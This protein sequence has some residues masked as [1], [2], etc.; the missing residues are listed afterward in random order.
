MDPKDISA[1]TGLAEVYEKKQMLKQAAETWQ[2]YQDKEDQKP[3]VT[4]FIEIYEKRGFAAARQ[5]YLEVRFSFGRR[6]IEARRA[7]G[8]A[9]PRLPECHARSKKA[10]IEVSRTGLRR[11]PDSA[12]KSESR[13]PI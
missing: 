1:L 7:M 5:E 13:F 4:S 2:V 9:K 3:Q 8:K 11:S 10:G 6:K 12:G